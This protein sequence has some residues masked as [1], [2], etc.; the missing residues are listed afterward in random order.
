MHLDRRLT[1]KEHIKKKRKQVQLK[2]R[3]LHWLIGRNTHTS[4]ENKILIY[5]T[6]IK[7]IWT[8]GIQLWGSACNSSIDIIQRSQSKTL[9][10]IANAPWY[11]TNNEI[12]HHTNM[13]TVKEEIEKA[14]ITYHHRLE[15]HPNILASGL[16]DT[17]NQRR[18]LKKF[19]P[20]DLPSRFG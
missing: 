13:N 12:H 18:R 15:F 9:R 19:K 7:P 3:Q 5:K 20:Q 10:Q 6:I 4:L 2:V 1:W 8:Y 16:T 17:S 11:A 14:S